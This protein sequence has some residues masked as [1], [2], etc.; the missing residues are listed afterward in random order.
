MLYSTMVEL[1]V[2][3]PK[4]VPFVKFRPSG[5]SG[6]TVNEPSANIVYDPV[7]LILTRGEAME[8]AIPDVE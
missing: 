4:I 8:P 1:T 3:V 6:V 5:K 7:N 2:G